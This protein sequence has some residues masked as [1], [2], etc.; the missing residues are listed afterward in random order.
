[1]LQQQDNDH[2][3]K[4]PCKWGLKCRDILDS[5]HC[6]KYSHQNIVQLQNENRIVC[7]W[8]NQCHDQ[9]SAHRLKYSHS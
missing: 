5:N 3:Q 6:T 7:K 9:S 8:G 2:N 1:S 4:I